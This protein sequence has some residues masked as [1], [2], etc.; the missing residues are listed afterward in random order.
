VAGEFAGRVDGRELSLQE[1]DA[2]LVM[3]G[4]G[5]TASV[6]K[7]S[8]LLS[9]ITWSGQ[10]LLL[11]PLTPNFWRAPTDNDFGNYM[12]DWAAVWE[13]AG[14]NRSLSS[15]E[16]IEDTDAR[17]VISAVHRFSDDTGNELADWR[18]TYTFHPSGAIDIENSMQRVDGL[19]VMPRVGMNVELR[20]ALE[21]VAWFGRGKFENYNDRKTA[22]NVG[23]Y[24]N[25]VAEHYV[26]YM[27]PQE[28]GYKTDVRWLSLSDAADAALLV[29]TD[30]LFPDARNE[31]GRVNVHVNDVVP[32]DIVSLDI[33]YGQMGV[34]GD[35]SWGKRTLQ[36]YSLNENSYH[37]AFTLQPY[38]PQDGRLDQL[39]SR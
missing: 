20:R 21:N 6:S 18:S 23:R 13:Q 24:S 27:R 9:S 8:G 25:T 4:E 36:K 19:P 22:A 11:T 1:T 28:N 15:L 7:D 26:P 29:T 10:E 3:H 2:A 39:V 5:F 34:G 31:R 33:D 32:R 30:K 38:T 14:R 16:T 17:I 12:H 37:Y 35:D